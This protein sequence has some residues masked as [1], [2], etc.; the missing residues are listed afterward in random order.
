MTFVYNEAT[1]TS[2]GKGAARLL[3][4]F[5][6][7]KKFASVTLSGHAD[8]RGLPNYNMELSRE[9]LATIEHVLRDGG[10]KGK[11]ELVPK[12]ANEPFSGI[13]RSKYPP[14]ELYQLDRRVELR[15]AD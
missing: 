5:L 6:T 2:E 1:L 10:Y 14:E 3:L 8:E 15:V 7:L 11:L 9:R 12:G 4:E 13:D